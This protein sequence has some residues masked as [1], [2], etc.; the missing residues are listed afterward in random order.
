VNG[1]SNVH[2]FVDHV[3]VKFIHHCVLNSEE[4]HE[5]IKL[6]ASTTVGLIGNLVHLVLL[7]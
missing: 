1:I 4:D 3:D 7:G 5:F 6:E 2:V